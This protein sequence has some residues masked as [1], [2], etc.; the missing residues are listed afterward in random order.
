MMERPSKRVKIDK[1][2]V[3]DERSITC[4]YLDTINR[5]RLDFDHEKVCSVSLS[6]TNVY[7]CLGKFN[8]DLFNER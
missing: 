8:D 5:S 1:T 4:P 2:D 3:T 6:N 7:A